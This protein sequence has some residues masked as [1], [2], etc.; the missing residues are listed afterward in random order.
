VALYTA[1]AFGALLYAGL[2]P[3]GA[4][5]LAALL[6]VGIA[7]LAARVVWHQEQRERQRAVS[8]AQLASAV[9]RS[10]PR[11]RSASPRTGLAREL[12]C[13]R[14]IQSALLPREVPFVEGYHLEVEYRPCGALG[15]DFYDFIPLDDGRLLM[16]LGDVSGKGPAGAIV[17]AMVQTLFRESARRADGPADLLRRVNE[18]FAGTMSKGI[19][20]TALAAILDPGRNQLS[21]AGAGHHPVLLLNPIERR[22][23]QV[24]ARGAALGVMTGREFTAAMVEA[25]IDLERGDC[26]LLFTDGATESVADFT[27]DIGENRFRAAA[28]AAVLPGPHG[29]L[30]RLGEDLYPAGGLRDDTTLLL[31]ARTAGEARGG[32]SPARFV[33]KTEQG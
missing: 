12:R 20:V 14:E 33:Q 27:G 19:F 21:L 6:G 4:C 8:A 26:L 15:G 32:N 18:G 17:M 30:R 13:G 24:G 31:V 9:E 5:V 11:S 22:S 10:R 2:D 7:F 23:T 1:A 16:T 25:T 29:A 3:V 28:A